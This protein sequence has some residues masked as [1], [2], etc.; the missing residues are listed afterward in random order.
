MDGTFS[1]APNFFVQLYVV[2]GSGGGP[3]NKIYPAAYLL[4]PNKQ[5]N[6]YQHAFSVLKERVGQMPNEIQIDF[7]LGA[8]KAIRQV[9]PTSDIRGLLEEECLF[10]C[11]H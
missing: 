4:L 3:V 1:T 10:K 8:I 5:A 2:F 9:F 7:E 11:W 6:T